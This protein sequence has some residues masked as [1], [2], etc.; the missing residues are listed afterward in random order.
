MPAAVPSWREWDTGEHDL[1]LRGE[2]LE[3]ECLERLEPARLLVKGHTHDLD[4]PL[5]VEGASAPRGRLRSRPVD[6]VRSPARPA[7]SR[8]HTPRKQRAARTAR[9]V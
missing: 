2:G 7:A 9:S 3:G 5:R 6:R 4:P 1:E 8:L